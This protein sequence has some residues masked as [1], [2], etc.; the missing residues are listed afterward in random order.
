MKEKEK[1][2]V[3]VDYL[4]KKLSEDLRVFL[5]VA[6]KEKPFW[7]MARDKRP[8]ATVE[9]V[10]E[11]VDRVR[12]EQELELKQRYTR[13]RERALALEECLVR[14]Q[15]RPDII[16]EHRHNMMRK[17]VKGKFAVAGQI[18]DKATAKGLPNVKVKAF[19]LNR[20]YGDRLG[21]TYSDGMGYYRIEYAKEDSG[22]LFDKKP[23]ICIEVLDEKGRSLSTSAKTFVHKAGEVEI[24]D[25]HIDGSKLPV[26]RAVSEKTA[27]SAKKRVEAYELR[28]RLI[29]SRAAMRSTETTWVEATMGKRPGIGVSA[30]EKINVNMASAEELMTLPGIGPA[31]AKAIVASRP[32]GTVDDLTAVSGISREMLNR[33]RKRLSV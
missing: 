20:K 6:S 11:M 7:L 26:S 15:R 18:I 9:A 19:D 30:T 27:R 8:R 14:R 5:K 23:E 2:L 24:I 12:K 28:R 3:N 33:L 13:V 17:A 29:V 32:F 31:K 22:D 4:A 10:G 21:S 25:V 16:A 1:H